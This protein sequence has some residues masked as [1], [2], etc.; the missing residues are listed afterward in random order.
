[1]N[2][3]Y[4]EQL[5]LLVSI[6]KWLVLAVLV[7]LIVGLSTALFLHAL[8][9]SVGFTTGYRWYFLAMPLTFVVAR[10]VVVRWAP[11]AEG[12]G[13][14]QIIRAIHT[15]SGRQ[16]LVVA[17]VKALATIVT[18]AS[19]G[20]AGKEGPS[21][22]IGAVLASGLADL[23]R[24]NDADRKRV[25]ICGISAG[26]SSVFGTPVA[27]AVFAIEVLYM[28][29]MVY[30]TLFPA[31]VAG[32]VSVATA[33]WLGIAR[34]SAW[35]GVPDG[36]TYSL[37]L[38]ALVGGLFFGLVA[39]LLVD[40]MKWVAAAFKRLPFSFVGRAATGGAL[41]VLSGLLFS[42]TYLG[43][44][45]SSINQ[46][47]GGTV[48]QPWDFLVKIA[49]T[50]ITLGAGGSGGVLTPIFFIGS[51]AGSFAGHLLQADPALFAALGL[52]AVLA[53]AANTPI[54]A[55]ILAVEMFGVEL[56]P[57]AAVAATVSYLITGH[58]GVYPSQI[59]SISKSASLQVARNTELERV[60]GSTFSVREG[61]VSQALYRW[62]LK[63]K[64]RAAR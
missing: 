46:Y 30:N 61:T 4:L 15:R 34:D 28:G 50:A 52:V 47:V 16:R 41:L 36:I 49:N 44:G 19:G 6:V 11:A 29:R 53:S 18:I 20:S 57:L 27:G 32:F 17:P 38:K 45:I 21:A 63:R 43:L 62:Y 9:F 2:I 23:F 1:M 39:L 12:H 24:L 37:Y 54:A 33:A 56:V 42:P 14:E 64:G 60:P 5:V 48:A 13:T 59:L 51:S 40:V 25:V 10:W 26:F 35:I 8:R 3:R 22:Q 31:V 58:R 55:I 7:G